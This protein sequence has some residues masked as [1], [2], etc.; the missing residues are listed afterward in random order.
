MIKTYLSKNPF[1]KALVA[2][3]SIVALIATGVFGYIF[4]HY[5]P[6]SLRP[7]TSNAAPSTWKV[8]VATTSPT[9]TD[10]VNSYSKMPAVVRYFSAISKGKFSVTYDV[11][12]ATQPVCN[13]SGASQAGL[14]ISGYNTIT[15]Y[16]PPV[17]FPPPGAP[18]PCPQWG[19]AN[20]N[21]PNWSHV[22]N[23]SGFNIMTVIHEIGHYAFGLPH[24][25]A[26]CATQEYA[27]QSIYKC[28]EYA[29]KTASVSGLSVIQPTPNPT[30][31]NRGD[32]YDVMGIANTSTQYYSAYSRAKIGWITS[33]TIS[34]SPNTATNTTLY[35]SGPTSNASPQSMI[36]SNY[37]LEY[38]KGLL[39]VRAKCIIPA[40]VPG[41][42]SDSTCYLTSLTAGQI[43]ND[44]TTKSWIKVLSSTSTAAQL[45]LGNDRN[46]T[47]GAT[48]TGGTG[49]TADTGTG[50][51]TDGDG[52]AC[53][54]AAPIVT[55]S[56][57]RQSTYPGGVLN[58]T[59]TVTNKGCGPRSY[60]IS[61]TKPSSGW[62]QLFGATTISNVP[63]R[64]SRTVTMAV[65]A[66]TTASNGL[67]SIKTIAATSTPTYT[68]FKGESTATFEVGN[69][70]VESFTVNGSAGTLSSG[71]NTLHLPANTTITLAWRCKNT[72][73]A[74][75]KNNNG[76][77]LTQGGATGSFTKEKTVT[78][79]R[80]YTLTCFSG[81]NLT[82]STGTKQ[83]K[84]ITP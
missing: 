30:Q 54:E 24:A 9:Y 65:T 35:D 71:V 4:N 68:V 67:Y 7:L 41:G 36:F 75:V 55:T 80:L 48:S 23:V 49:G 78:G 60:T 15:Y 50:G 28:K 37:V 3:L 11:K 77:I 83:I 53:T 52:T 79:T 69:P 43:F 59:V 57:L 72:Q 29:V 12:Q 45:F 32:I 82:G 18:T 61:G 14:N 46:P 81:T 8:L 44:P 70:V 27:S 31:R 39:H 76:F 16:M 20:N 13:N 62:K 2:T 42:S 5:N 33:K 40:D 19:T 6:N 58:Y 38:E 63:A 47:Q 56:P 66:P 10:E 26:L 25:G 17:S 74:S 1:T 84:I 22:Y 51:T 73:S 21:P 34:L 64:T